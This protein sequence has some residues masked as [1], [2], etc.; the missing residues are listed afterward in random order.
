[1]FASIPSPSSGSVHVGPLQLRASGL[2]IALG[3]IAAV[4]L[5]GRR[6]AERGIGSPDD[7]GAI[8]VWAVPAGIVGARAYHVA[9]D[10]E[11]FRGQWHKVF[12]VWEGGLGIWGGVAAGV[13]V[14]LWVAHRRSSASIT[15]T[16][17]W[18]CS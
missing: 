11:F 8:A 15:R 10:P 16:R 13:A 1:M 17:S 9:T 4:W 12:F 6:V 7:I 3:V 14:G 18:A 2:L 5:A